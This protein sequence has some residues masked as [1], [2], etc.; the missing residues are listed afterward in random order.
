MQPKPENELEMSNPL[1]GEDIDEIT[2]NT[3]DYGQDDE[4]STWDAVGG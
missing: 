4:S 2:I 1:V 3:E